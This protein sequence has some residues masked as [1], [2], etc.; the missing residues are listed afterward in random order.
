MLKRVLKRK[1]IEMATIFKKSVQ[2]P[3]P[4]RQIKTPLRSHL[5]QCQNGYYRKNRWQ[6]VLVICEEK[7]SLIHCCC[8]SKLTCPLWKSMQRFL[9]RKTEFPYDPPPTLL[10]IH[11]KESTLLQ[12]DSC[13]LTFKPLYSH[14][15][16]VQPA[17]ISPADECIRN[18]SANTQWNF[19]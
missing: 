4:F 16:A 12:R 1:T 18:C 13:A 17:Q 9:R 11:T 7:G 3:Y 8:E 6:Q 15:E 19:I 10:G 5:Y 14:R 2:H